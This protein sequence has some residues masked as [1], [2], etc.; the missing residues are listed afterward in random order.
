MELNQNSEENCSGMPEYS[1]MDLMWMKEAMAEADAAASEGEVPVGA[2]IGRDGRLIARGHNLVETL[3]SSDAH[4][5][6]VAIRRAE[7][8]LEAKW[9]TGC[10]MYV[11]L[12]PCSMCAGAI[13]LARLDKLFIGTMD[14]KNG[15]CGSLS[16]IPCDPRLNH[17]AEVIT[18]LY[19]GECSQQLKDFFRQMRLKK[20]I[21]EPED[22]K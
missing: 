10:S 1:E 4:A 9:L 6:M 13:V 22:D 20:N 15:A 17:R 21:S 12:E 5:E 7:K 16:N 19:A 18:G 11:T 8:A 14:P 2:V 3:K